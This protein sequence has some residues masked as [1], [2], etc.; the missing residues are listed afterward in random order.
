MLPM[1]FVQK[2]Y[3][4]RWDTLDFRKDHIDNDPPKMAPDP[5]PMTFGHFSSNATIDSV[6]FFMLP[7]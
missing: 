6:R 5:P 3:G 2:N 4:H 1:P 7:I